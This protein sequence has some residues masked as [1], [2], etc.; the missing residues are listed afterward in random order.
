MDSEKRLRKYLISRFIL[1]LLIVLAAETLMI[2][3][4]NNVI[5]PIATMSFFPE[6]AGLNLGSLSSIIKVILMPLL[7]IVTGVAGNS[8]PAD[9]G[10]LFRILSILAS[11][12]GIRKVSDSQSIAAFYAD[13]TG[14]RRI[15]LIAFLFSLFILIILP[16]IISILWYSFAV[17]RRF[18]E[19]DREREM[20]RQEEESKRYLMISDIVHDLKTP[21]TTVSGYAKALT[22]GIVPEKDKDEY[23]KAISLKTERMNEIVLLL[24]DYVKLDSE[25]FKIVPSKIDLSEFLRTIAAEKYT[26]IESAGDEL[27]IDIPETPIPVKAD[28]RQFSRVINNLIANAVKHNPK[29]TKIGFFVKDDEYDLRIFVADSGNLIDKDFAEK[30]FDPFVTGDK[31]RSSSGGTGL[32]LSVSKKICDLHKFKMRL[33]QKPDIDRLKLDPKYNKVFVITIDKV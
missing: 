19:L 9:S 27:D 33:V 11:G 15:A 31:S 32:G 10:L 7:L 2:A 18:N 24:L 6:L 23:L 28:A 3:F 26:D 21:M 17:L 14:G 30:I 1:V 16:V 12:L 4:L 5:I 13:I 25:G 20:L 29:G 22:D 8:L